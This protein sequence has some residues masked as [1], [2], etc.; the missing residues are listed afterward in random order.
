MDLNINTITGSGTATGIIFVQKADLLVPILCPHADGLIAS[1]FV[2]E[3]SRHL[4]AVFVSS[5]IKHELLYNYI[6]IFV[7][8]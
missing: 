3:G 7:M 5:A 1:A 6:Q 8:T 4:R 2:F